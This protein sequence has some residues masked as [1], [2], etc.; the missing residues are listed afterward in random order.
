MPPGANGSVLL[1][2]CSISNRPS[3]PKWMPL[4]DGRRQADRTS[5][6]WLQT[7]VVIE[8]RTR[9]QSE[10]LLTFVTEELKRRRTQ[11]M[12]AGAALVLSPC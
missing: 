1:Q 4:G 5:Q 2:K 3:H 12:P 10:F 9:Q 8:A 6:P 7:F 11:E